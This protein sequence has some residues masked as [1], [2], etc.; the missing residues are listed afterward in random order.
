MIGFYRIKIIIEELTELLD[1]LQTLFTKMFFF[2]TT[3]F[4]I[5]QL[6]NFII[7]Q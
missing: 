6:L 2:T 4:T 5:Y 7:K 1:S 3:I